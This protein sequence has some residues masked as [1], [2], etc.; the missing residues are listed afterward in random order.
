MWEVKNHSRSE[1]Q[2]MIEALE[3]R[4]LMSAVSHAA[5]VKH[6]PAPHAIVMSVKP[7]AKPKATPAPKAVKAMPAP[8]VAAKAKVTP[9]AKT[10]TPPVVDDYPA[11]VPAAHPNMAP[12]MVGTWT[13]TITMDGSKQGA[14]FSIDFAFQRGTAA[15]GAFHLGPAVGNQTV[16][17]TLVFGTSRN[18]RALVLTSTLWVGFNGALTAN[19]NMLYGRVA[20]NTSNGWQTGSFSVTRN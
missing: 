20:V 5:V 2:P 18:A 1:V 3:S 13:G 10:V 8:K 7:A 9:A 4:E 6:A 14:V 11:Y 17:S 19:G 15:S 16:T 12:D